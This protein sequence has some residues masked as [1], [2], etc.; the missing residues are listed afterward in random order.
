MLARDAGFVVAPVP[1]ALAG[2]AVA[3]AAV[4][5]V[6]VIALAPPRLTGDGTAGAVTA[7][8]SAAVTLS[9]LL[10]FM[11]MLVA[12]RG[13]PHGRTLTVAVTLAAGLATATLG[14]PAARPA[15]GPVSRQ[16]DVGRPVGR[17]GQTR[18]S[19]GAGALLL[20]TG[21]GA[22][23]WAVT[24]ALPLASLLP[25]CA[26]AGLLALVAHQ[27]VSFLLFPSEVRRP[28]AAVLAVAAAAPGRAAPG[29]APAP[30]R[31]AHGA[32]PVPSRTS[33]GAVPAPGRTS[34][35]AAPAPGRS[36]QRAAEKA[37]RRRRE[38]ALLL[39][40]TLPLA[41]AAPAAYI[42]GRLLVG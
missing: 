37:A 19:A 29:A 13:T 38:A 24:P 21:V 30:L 7:S 40:A 20:A 41:L 16:R 34:H 14:L 28:P 42:L 10:V 8:M 26:V 12:E 31:A 27:V 35:G 18:G 15:P 11:S 2:V 17:D 9:V 32:V 23:T 22:A 1:L 6:A 33:R 39:R 5:A 4:A 3:G 36:A 25:V